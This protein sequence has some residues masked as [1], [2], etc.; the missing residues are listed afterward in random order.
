MRGQQRVA[1]GKSVCVGEE[2]SKA[3][4]FCINRPG[5]KGRT[6]CLLLL[7]DGTGG[8]NSARE[9]RG[10]FFTERLLFFFF[11]FLQGEWRARY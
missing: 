3:E 11:S 2:P 5:W 8:L 1:Q 6:E 4:L 9:M 7:V 10:C